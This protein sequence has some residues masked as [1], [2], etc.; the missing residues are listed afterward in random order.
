MDLIESTSDKV[1]D[2]LAGRTSINVSY[3]LNAI[4]PGAGIIID[5]T[6]PNEVTVAS[7]VTPYTTV[8]EIN[9][10][11]A[12]TPQSTKTLKLSLYNTYFRHKNNGSST[13]LTSNV[14][15]KI[16]DTTV[17]WRKGQQFQLVIDDQIESAGYT[18]TIKTD[19]KNKLGQST[20]YSKT[21]ATL[22]NSDFPTTYGRNGRPI[23]TIIC[24]D[25]RTLDFIVDKIIR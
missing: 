21:I 2:L 4:R 25:D 22:T 11:P 12:T 5:K 6:I 19:A 1:D 9:L 24:K 13:T 15:I 16:D 17:D 23:I 8:E 18:I 3:N 10:S 20:A 7:D 14:T